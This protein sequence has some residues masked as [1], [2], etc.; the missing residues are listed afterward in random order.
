MVLSRLSVP[1]PPLPW[2][3]LVRVLVSTDTRFSL[4]G[5]PRATRLFRVPLDAI[6]HAT[7]P[8][9]PTSVTVFAHAHLHLS[10]YI[11]G[12][13]SF[14]DTSVTLLAQVQAHVEF[15]DELLAAYGPEMPRW[16]I[17]SRKC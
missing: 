13:R 1:S 5:Q 14:H 12:D 2:L 9:A 10:S 7:I 6:Y 16:G 17:E 11:D 3:N 15:L 8:S 4:L